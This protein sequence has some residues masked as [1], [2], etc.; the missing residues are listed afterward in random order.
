VSNSKKSKAMK[1]YG[2]YNINDKTA[3]IISTGKFDNKDQALGHFSSRKQM[4]IADFSKLFYIIRLD[5]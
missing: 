4:S 5:D 3:E 1:K 2:F